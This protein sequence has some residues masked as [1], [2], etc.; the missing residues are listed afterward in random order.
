M[1]KIASKK[2]PFSSVFLMDPRPSKWGY[3]FGKILKPL[4]DTSTVFREMPY[5]ATV[6]QQSEGMLI[7]QYNNTVSRSKCK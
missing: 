4:S 6:T 7:L 1:S 5:I 2:V 3:P